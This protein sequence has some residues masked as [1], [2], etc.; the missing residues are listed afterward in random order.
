MHNK[1]VVFSD[2][3]ESPRKNKSLLEHSAHNA[4]GKTLFEDDD[5]GDELNFNI[6]KHFEGKNGQKVNNKIPIITRFIHC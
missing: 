2:N 5:S 1:K 4:K 6:K 3:E